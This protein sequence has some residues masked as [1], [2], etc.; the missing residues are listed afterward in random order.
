MI[1]VML[2]ALMAGRTVGEY[3]LKRENMTDIWLE[4]IPSTISVME[5]IRDN[6]CPTLKCT[7]FH[8][9]NSHDNT[10]LMVSSKDVSECSAVFEMYPLQSWKMIQDMKRIRINSSYYF[11]IN[12]NL[13]YASR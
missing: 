12:G 2:F 13:Y 11:W 8:F 9:K 6:Q 3:T 7:D 1:K 4:G 5:W 10:C